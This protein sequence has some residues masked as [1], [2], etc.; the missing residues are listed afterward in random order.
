MEFQVTPTTTPAPMTTWL[1]HVWLVRYLD[2]E[3]SD[4]ETRWFEAYVLDKPELLAVIEGDTSLRDALSA[5]APKRHIEASVEHDG[6]QSS[7]KSGEDS[8]EMSSRPRKHSESGGRPWVQAQWLAMAASLMLGLG[9]GW[10]GTRMVGPGHEIPDFI[11]SPT[12]ILYDTMRG[13]V[14]APLVERA[15]S[16]SQYVL[17]QVAVPDGATDILLIVDDHPPVALT[18]ETDGFV[19]ALLRRGMITHGHHAMIQYTLDGQARRRTLDLTTIS[20]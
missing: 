3:L 19:S 5:V 11:A 18:A 10:L 16:G 8:M 7:T 9:V 15:D 17:V 6:N 12:R 4:E 1:E 13:E 20:M 14:K 2:R